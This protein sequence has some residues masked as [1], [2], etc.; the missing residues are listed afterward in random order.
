MSKTVLV[1]TEKPFNSAAIPQIRKIVEEAGYRLE[2]LEKY[3][4][5]EELLKAAEGA[6]A[7]IVR[8]DKVTKE[9][10]DAAKGLEIVVRAGAGY[11]SIDTQ[12][13][14]EKGIIVENTPGQNANAVGELA[15]GMLVYTVRNHFNGKSGSEL[16]GRKLGFHAFGHTA[17]NTARIAR[18]FG[19]ELYCYEPFFEQGKERSPKEYEDV[20]NLPTV[21]DLYKT[22]DIVSLH[23]P[24]T[25]E[26]N[27]SIGYDLVKNM[28]KGGILMNMA[29]QE[30]I[31]EKGLLKLLEERE[32]LTYLTD[33][34]P[35]NDE[36]YRDR[37]GDRYF[38]TPKKMG[39]QTVEANINAGLAAARQ[40]VSFFTS[41]E[42]KFQVNK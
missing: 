32:D 42:V 7:L 1:A 13:A 28:P 12:Y 17:R 18:G 25:P 8:S 3:T 27:G 36:E 31:D 37:L 6:N 5:K 21:E 9:V 41:G 24:N 30:I 4:T 34:K 22:C 40:I 16:K 39:A 20:T 23:L 2:V 19:L 35:G 33:I 29:R 10:I 15:F 14:K 38:A 26:T 11:D